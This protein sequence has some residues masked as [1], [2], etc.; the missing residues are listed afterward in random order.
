M[1]KATIITVVLF[2]TAFQIFSFK[3]LITTLGIYRA[4]SAPVRNE[5]SAPPRWTNWR[6]RL[7]LI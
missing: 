2:I 4:S 7:S 3:A 6:Q 1:K 5:L